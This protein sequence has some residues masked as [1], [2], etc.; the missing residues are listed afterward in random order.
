VLP[1][2]FS[3]TN[4]QTVLAALGFTPQQIGGLLEQGV[5]VA[6]LRGMLQLRQFEGAPADVLIDIA[7]WIDRIEQIEKLAIDSHTA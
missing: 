7:A 1:T 5:T 2:E 6:Q 4:Y 3:H